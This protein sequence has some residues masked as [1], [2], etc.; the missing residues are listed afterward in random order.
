MINNQKI[1]VVIPTKNEEKM[2]KEIINK[3]RP[4]ADEILVIDNYSI[5]KIKMTETI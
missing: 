3:V 4:Y 2:I 5:D 1:S